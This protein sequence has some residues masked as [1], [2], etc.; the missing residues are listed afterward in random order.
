M[1]D[2]PATLFAEVKAGETEMQIQLSRGESLDAKNQTGRSRVALRMSGHGIRVSLDGIFG[3]CNSATVVAVSAQQNL[4][5]F[6]NFLT[7]PPATGG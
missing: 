2:N 1:G 7:R 4:G 6:A 5:D 3:R